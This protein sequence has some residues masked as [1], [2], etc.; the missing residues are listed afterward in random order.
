MTVISEN[1]KKMLVAK[2]QL[3]LHLLSKNNY[4][5]RPATFLLKRVTNCV[6]L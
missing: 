1:L 4:L 5:Q 3:R 2:Y 6:S